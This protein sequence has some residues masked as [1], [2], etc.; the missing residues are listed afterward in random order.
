MEYQA[1][2]KIF[3]DIIS[4]IAVD[5]EILNMGDPI[6]RREQLDPASMNF[7]DMV[8]ELKKRH[9]IEVPSEDDMIPA[10]MQNCIEYLSPKF[11]FSS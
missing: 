9:K 1:I 5:E 6:R 4:D 10:T 3:M 2:R 8:M 11:S 7:P